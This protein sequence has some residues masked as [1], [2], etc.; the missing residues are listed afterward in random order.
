MARELSARKKY[1]YEWEDLGRLQGCGKRDEQQR[2]A[3][4]VELECSPVEMIVFQLVLQ[5]TLFR[6]PGLLIRCISADQT[7]IHGYY[8]PN[9]KLT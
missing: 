9:E 8:L 5:F 7:E 2:Q 1:V 3:F 6:V 4:C